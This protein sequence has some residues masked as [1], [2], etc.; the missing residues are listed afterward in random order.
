MA[1]E[2]LRIG[3]SGGGRMNGGWQRDGSMN[4]GRQRTDNNHGGWNNNNG[5]QFVN[6]GRHDD[7]RR[8]PGQLTRVNPQRYQAR[9]DNV[10]NFYNN[11]NRYHNQSR[12]Q[13]ILPRYNNHNYRDYRDYNGGYN[14]NYNWGNYGGYNWGNYGGYN[15]GNYNTDNYCLGIDGGMIPFFPGYG[16]FF[17]RADGR[18]YMNTP[19]GPRPVDGR[20]ITRSRNNHF[21]YK[22]PRG[23]FRIQVGRHNGRA[24]FDYNNYN[25]GVPND[26]YWGN[27][28][29]NPNPAVAG[30]QAPQAVPSDNDLPAD[31]IPLNDIPI[32]DIPEEDDANFPENSPQDA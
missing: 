10:G 31:D 6:N 28:F 1:Y 5:G 27:R 8:N 16:F 25:Q 12:H 32:E 13:E 2:D 7:D 14:N 26:P 4:N 15:W 20:Y 30:N 24:H 9:P 29:F 11:Q 23:R 19:Y 18:W 22:G 21:Y 17:N 3:R